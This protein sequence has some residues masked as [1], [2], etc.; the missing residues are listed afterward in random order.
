[1]FLITIKGLFGTLLTIVTAGLTVLICKWLYENKDLA[2]NKK[3][4]FLD[5]VM[6]LTA[7]DIANY[8]DQLWNKHGDFK[9]IFYI[10]ML[11][12]LAWFKRIHKWMCNLETG[13][14]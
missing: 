13:F 3:F 10:V 5:V 7:L 4:I 11:F 8:Y 6:I 12:G 14:K 9:D 2:L 1:M